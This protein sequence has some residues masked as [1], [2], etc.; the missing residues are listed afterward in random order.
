MLSGYFSERE[1][2][3]FRVQC[4]GRVAGVA[5]E[6]GFCAWCHEF[7]EL[8][9]RRDLEAAFDVGVD[10][11]ENDPAFKTERVVVRVERFDHDELVAFVAGYLK[12]EV[13]R[14]ASGHCD[15]D[16]GDGDLD[17]DASVVFLCQSLAQFRQARRIGVGNVVESVFAHRLKGAFGGFDVRC[18]DIEVIDFDAV[19]LGRVGERHKLSDSG[20]R[21][22]ARFF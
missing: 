2:I 14:L 7:L 4:S 5:D 18:A 8:F 12:R 9:D 15:D 22:Q 21:H 3:L 1:H 6:D 11:F 19:V 10:R 17:A 20:S 16:L 13:D